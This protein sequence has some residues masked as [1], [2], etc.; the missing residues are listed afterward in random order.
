MRGRVIAS[1]CLAAAFVTVLTGCGARE[2]SRPLDGQS[3]SAS[4]TPERYPSANSGP[5]SDYAE[6]GFTAATQEQAQAIV[7][8]LLPLPEQ[9]LGRSRSSLLVTPPEWGQQ[10][11]VAEYGETLKI[12]VSDYGS[13]EAANEAVKIDGQ[14]PLS[15]FV[16]IVKVGSLETLVNDVVDVPAVDDAQGVALP[17]TGVRV[18][19]ARV[20]FGRDALVYRLYSKTMSAEDM[21]SV[22][23][24]MVDDQ[25]RL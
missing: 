4:S 1:A 25:N 18:N 24:E 6:A 15:D 13:A 20:V 11:I 12:T 21:L 16:R 17:G 9:A 23:R 7:N 22:V 19:Y 5:E 2:V 3:V 10:G 8:G 14:P